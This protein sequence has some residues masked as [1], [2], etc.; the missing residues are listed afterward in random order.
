MRVVRKG[1]DEIRGAGPP[2]LAPSDRGSDP[3]PCMRRAL[4]SGLD[5]SCCGPDARIAASRA[6][7]A[8]VAMRPGLVLCTLE[9]R[10]AATSRH[11]VIPRC[12]HTD[13]REPGDAPVHPRLRPSTS[14][15]GQ[16]D[17]RRGRGPASHLDLTST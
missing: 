6:D 13:G 17:V 2:R 11:R 4:R 10:K 5:L 7:A 14:S 1:V 3:H 15:C 12:G 9:V 8:V 16:V